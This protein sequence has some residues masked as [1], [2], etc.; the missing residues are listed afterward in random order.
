MTGWSSTTRTPIG[1]AGGMVEDWLRN[2]K[3]LVLPC[4]RNNG[5]LRI[6]Y[7]QLP[8]VEHDGIRARPYSRLTRRRYRKLAASERAFGSLPRRIEG[9]E[10]MKLGLKALAAA[11][12][13]GVVFLS[14]CAVQAQTWSLVWSDEANGAAN[15]LPD[16]SKWVYDNPT[17]GSSNA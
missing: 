10:P 17:A 9:D 2:F 11:L 7:E 3:Q 16:S 1:L 4:R 12:V 15:V 5:V 6:G 14:P 8:P 13:V